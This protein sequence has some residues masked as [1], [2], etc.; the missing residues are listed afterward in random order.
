MQKINLKI[1]TKEKHT[2]SP[3]IYMQFMEPLGTCDTSVDAAWDYANERWIPK[4]IDLVR[5]DLAPTMIRFGGCFASY[6]HWKE[7]VGPMEKRVPMVNYC[8]DGLY[9]N[10]VGTHELIDF[11]RQV[12]AD[13]L[14]V[15]NMESDGREKWAHPK[16]GVDRLGTAEEAAEWVDYCNNPD[17]ALR[18]AHGHADPYNVKFW[19][20]GNETSYDAAGFTSDQCA[21]VT[22][23][24]AKAMRKVDPSIRLLGWGDES[25]KGLDDTWCAK[26][27]QIDEIDTIAF[28]HHFGSGLDSSPLYGDHYRISPKNTWRHLMNAYRSMEDHIAKMRE[29]ANG[30]RLAMTEGHFTVPGQSRNTVLSTW[31]AGVS[32]ARCLNVIERNSDILDIATMADFMGNVWQVNAIMLS[33][34][35][36]ITSKPSYLQPVGRVMSLFRKHVGEKALDL[37][38]SGIVDAT[39]SRTGKTIFIHAANTAMNEDVELNVDLGKEKIKKVTMHYVAKDPMT[40]ITYLNPNVFNPKT[41]EVEGNIVLPAAAVAAIEIELE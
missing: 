10:H 17:N 33:T 2:I 25:H 21:K 15:V 12:N 7:A 27:G 23:K 26:M 39:A 1:N 37:T 6:Y 20:I 9:S 40:H 28:H 13:P 4:V 34:P 22:E 14:I 11:C 19:Q 35:V 5:D 32:Y 8:W 38:S 31:A 18:K 41:V 36:S 29:D 16:P 24:F 3:Y 30:K